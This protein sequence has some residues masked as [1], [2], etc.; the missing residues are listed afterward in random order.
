MRLALLL[1]V[2][3]LFA[4]S[5]E[6]SPV[7]KKPGDPVTLQLFANS[8]KTAPLG[9]RWNVIFP[10]QLMDLESFEPGRAAR[11]SGKS[12]ECNREKEKEYS[13]LCFLSGGEKLITD[14]QVAVFHFHIHPDA[15][16]QDVILR[17]E[18]AWA[19]EQNN[20]VAKLNSTKSVFIIR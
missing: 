16:P 18:D 19:I 14:G 1:A 3:P 2:L 15:K 9:L 13:Y 6:K 17:I 8:P 5:P 10:A 4:Q 11:D 7:L 12:L 20:S